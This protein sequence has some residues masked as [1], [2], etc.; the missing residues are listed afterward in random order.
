V[1]QKFVRFLVAVAPLIAR[2]GDVEARR[3]DAPLHAFK[4]P[5]HVIGDSTALAPLRFGDR[6]ADG[7]PAPQ[8]T[9]GRAE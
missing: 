3:N 7:W 9:A 2:Y 1:E 6:D 4:A 5:H 8:L